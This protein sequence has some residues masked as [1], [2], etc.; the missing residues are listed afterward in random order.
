MFKYGQ[1]V[2]CIKAFPDA[3]LKLGDIRVV[4]GMQQ[5]CPDLMLDVGIPIPYGSEKCI[6]C[7]KTFNP[8][9]KWWINTWHFAP[10]EEKSETN[11]EEFL[12]IVPVKIQE[13]H[14]N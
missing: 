7:G 12:N 11:V 5:I 8:N 10:L 3:G 14:K 2:I 1:K 6:K 4:K 9:G 13:I